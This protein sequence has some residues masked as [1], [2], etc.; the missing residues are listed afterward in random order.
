MGTFVCCYNKPAVKVYPNEQQPT[1]LSNHAD[2]SEPSSLKLKGI[3]VE[4]LNGPHNIL[5]EYI[6]INKVANPEQEDSIKEKK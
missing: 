2:V 4:Q 6:F 3:F 5:S 1:N